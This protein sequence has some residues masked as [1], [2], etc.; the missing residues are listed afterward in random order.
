MTEDGDVFVGYVLA[1][2]DERYL[3]SDPP[4]I[5]KMMDEERARGRERKEWGRGLANYLVNVRRLPAGEAL[6]YISNWNRKNRSPLTQAGLEQ[7]VG[8]VASR[9]VLPFCH[10]FR[11]LCNRGMCALA[12]PFYRCLNC[13]ALISS[14]ES[15]PRCPRCGGKIAYKPRTDRVR[16]VEAI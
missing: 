3:G 11:R 8:D 4:C 6:D 12:G 14:K 7:I 5:D 9:G 10:I 16:R 2:P 1:Y 13:N 15:A